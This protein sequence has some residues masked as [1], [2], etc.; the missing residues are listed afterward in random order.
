[1]VKR[2]Q[3]LAR[4]AGAAAITASRFE[5]GIAYIDGHSALR[6][7]ADWG[8]PTW[9]FTTEGRERLLS[10]I[11]LIFD[12][13]PAR[14]VLEAAWVG[15]PIKRTEPIARAKLRELIGENQLGN[16]VLYIVEAP[17]PW[18]PLRVG[19]PERT[20]TQEEQSLLDEARAHMSAIKPFRASSTWASLYVGELTLSV[21][22][23]RRPLEWPRCR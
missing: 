16:R 22:L 4:E 19:P 3:Q 20:L 15:E 12:N 18:F 10:A 1:V 13:L 14:F 7:D 21:P 9:S 5:R 2:L 8:A 11:D 23:D 6:E 17:D